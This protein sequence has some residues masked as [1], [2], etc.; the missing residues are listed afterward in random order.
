[1]ELWLKSFSM[2]E[3]A[4][5][6]CIEL[7][8]GIIPSMIS[9]VHQRTKIPVITGGLVRTVESIEEVLSAGAVAITTSNKDLRGNFNNKLTVWVTFSRM[10]VSSSA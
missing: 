3:S 1:M 8:S 2:I 10:Y 9:E 5:P 4:M 7:L 6:D